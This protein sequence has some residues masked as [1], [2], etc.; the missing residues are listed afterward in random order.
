MPSP[1]SSTPPIALRS[2]LIGHYAND[3]QASMERFDERIERQLMESGAFHRT[4]KPP[5]C[6]GR[7]QRGASGIGKW[8]GYLDKFV[9]F[10]LLIRIRLMRMG[11]LA[12][13][14]LFILPD[15]SHGPYVPFVSKLPHVVHVHDMIA[16]RTAAGAF[17]GQQLSRTGRIYQRCIVRGLR[18]ARNFLCISEATR[19]D[20]L[21]WVEPEA[22]HCEVVWNELN[23]PYQRCE[24]DEPR[25][26]GLPELSENGFLLHVGNRLWYKNRPG[27]LRIFEAFSTHAAHAHNIDLV[28]VG[29]AP[30]ANDLS[31]LASREL[32]KRVHFLQSIDCLALQWLYSRSLGLL[33]PSHHEGFGWPI[34]EA[35]ACGCPVLTTRQPPMSEIGSNWVDYVDPMPSVN[36]E[37]SLHDWL[38]S[39]VQVLEQW[40]AQEPS[41]RN[42]H[43]RS[44]IEYSRRFAVGS[45]FREYIRFYQTLLPS[46][47]SNTSDS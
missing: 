9:I 24:P 13:Q 31:W 7:I 4:W 5:V 36:E 19:Q 39:A 17:P 33:F 43:I 47:G 40:L 23:F 22:E 8:L 45:A 30:D 20:L 29:D 10:P 28:I 15:H 42:E 11:S 27:V 14:T 46:A 32:Q 26:S 3:E 16:I 12:K 41:A 35:L 2:I 21:R 38:R 34:I 25:P 6:L 37:A 18:N 1:T 44:R